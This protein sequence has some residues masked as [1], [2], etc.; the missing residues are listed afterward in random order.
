MDVRATRHGVPAG[1][2]W[3][4][5][6]VTAWAAITILIGGGS[7]HADEQDDSP[8]SPLTSLVGDTVKA[9]TAPVAPVVQQVV[10]PVV[11]KVVAPVQQVAPAVV[12]TVSNTVAKVP[13]VGPA[14]APVVHT[15]TETT[16]QI[17]KPV[18][19]VLQN[20]PVSQIT[21]PVLD[22][23]AALPV[24]GSLVDDLGVPTV[25]RDVVGIVDDTTAL[26][27]GVTDAVVPPVLEGLDPT[28]PAP[29][30]PAVDGPLADP[31]T[32]AGQG[33]AYTSSVSLSGVADAE[34]SRTATTAV[35]AGSPASASAVGDSAPVAPPIPF[36]GTSL[37]SSSSAGSGGGVG[38][39]PA[40]PSDTG[41]PAPPAVEQVFGASDDVLPTSPIADTDVS[42]D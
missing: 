6:G 24:I 29:T 14:T 10:A 1:V 22:A 26:I 21:T 34:A 11:T 8:L 16:Q 15:V 28:T 4:A 12:A 40:G 42:P 20:N 39:A 13:V 27:G 33:L 36:N 23:V 35:T 30:T 32:A 19:A 7:A 38:P 17:V 31:G 25:V 5:I 41:I 37:P 9:V 3:G 18:T 2:L